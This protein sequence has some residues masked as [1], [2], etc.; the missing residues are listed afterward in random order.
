[1]IKI[2]EQGEVLSYKYAV[3]QSASYELELAISGLI[4]AS[5]HL[6]VDDT[7]CTNNFEELMSQMSKVGEKKYRQKSLQKHGLV[8]RK[9]M[10]KN[11]PQQGVYVL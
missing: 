7:V 4:K 8:K 11:L 3:P 9:M 1:M 6:V 5:K 10:L 2:T